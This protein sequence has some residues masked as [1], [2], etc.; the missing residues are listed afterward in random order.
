M[1]S[2]DLNRLA[3]EDPK[4]LLQILQDAKRKAF[5]PHPA[6]QTILDSNARYRVANCGRRFG[7]SELASHIL[8]TKSRKPNQ[9]LW[10]VAPT[11]AVVKRGYD[12][13]IK[14]L[15]EGVLAKPAPPS[16]NFDQ[17][18]KVILHFKNGTKMEF[19][20][21]ERPDGM[22]GAAVDFVV[23][24]EAAI[25]PAH[26]W[27]Q[28]VRPTLLDNDGGAFMISTPRGKNWFYDSWLKGQDP[29]NTAWESWTY[30]SKDNPFLPEGAA[31]EM[32]G[33]L[34]RAQAQ[35]EIYAVWLA[36][37]AQ[38]FIIPSAAQDPGVVGEDGRVYDVDE[39]G[40]PVDKPRVVTGAVFLGVD[41]AR[42]NDYTVMYGAR[43]IDRQ[44][45]YFERFNNI[46]WEEQRRRIKRAVGTL[47]RAGAEY[48]MLMVDE[49]N[50]GTII[51][52]DLQEA[53]FTC[54]GVNFTSKKQNMVR[55]LATD[56]EVGHAYVLKDDPE[57][58]YS[59]FENYAM[60]Q[61]AR[62][63]LQ[64]SAPDGQ[65]DD[66]VS[67]K[68]LSHWGCVNF[69]AGNVQMV[70]PGDPSVD[71]V[72]RDPWEDEDDD[73]ADLLDEDAQAVY[74]IGLS[75]H[76]DPRDPWRQPTVAELMNRP[77]IWV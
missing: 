36:E 21:A 76:I 20:S 42:T 49:G 25:M 2:P 66:V 58:Q 31:E 54:E 68:L 48:V 71:L 27:N 62:G 8:I 67:A 5:R 52:E 73:A 1:A 10:W 41:L 59:E 65:H 9:L 74:D 61:S 51:I 15:P 53:G 14:K 69:G 55:L 23:L 70:T 35:Q 72:E 45:V 40:D 12:M 64:Y 34:P 47:M 39:Y 28:N 30:T 26:I 17:G 18:R 57:A 46:K 60:T 63:V 6:Q 37:G 16:S 56:L 33:D 75:D 13:V 32:A 29:K 3:Q 22:L 44:N 19:Y 38:V 11:Y 77:D 4:Q 43:E 50:G 7:K 24:D